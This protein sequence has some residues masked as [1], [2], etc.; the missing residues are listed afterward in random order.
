MSETIKLRCSSLDRA[1]DC[2]AS[3]I[4]PSVKIEVANEAGS[5]GSGAHEHNAEMVNDRRVDVDELAEKWFNGGDKDDFIR[6]RDQLSKLCGLS[7]GAW[8]RLRDHFPNPEAEVEMEYLDEEFNILLTGHADLL[9]MV[10]T[11]AARIL[12]W[13]SGWA[14]REHSNQVRGYAFLLCKRNPAIETVTVHVLNLRRGE[15]DTQEYTRE[16]LEAW[17]RGLAAA[18]V[19]MRDTHRPSPEACGFCQRRHECAARAKL[20]GQ[21]IVLLDEMRE[22]QSPLAVAPEQLATILEQARMIESFCETVR[23]LVKESVVS[24]GGVISLEDGREL[25]IEVGEKRQIDFAAAEGVIQAK[26]GDRWRE[27]VKIVNKDVEK[28]V[29]ETA[30]YRGKGKAI[31]EFWNELADADAIQFVPVETLKI[32]G[33]KRLTRAE[34]I[35]QEPETAGV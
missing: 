26:L 19:T 9:S 33:G 1:A 24:A 5:L 18:V 22:H 4:N 13:K 2:P 27:A 30:P 23:G 3:T 8:K 12:D 25:A 31:K 10:G 14:D 6:F 28:L 11:V 7:R 29:G 21:A 16:E 34:V 32:R 20:L 15:L 17:W 35:V